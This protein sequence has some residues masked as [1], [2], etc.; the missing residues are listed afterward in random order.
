MIKETVELIGPSMMKKT[1]AIFVNPLPYLEKGKKSLLSIADIDLINALTGSFKIDVFCGDPAPSNRDELHCPIHHYLLFQKWLP[2][3]K[4]KNILYLLW[5]SGFHRYIYPLIEIFPGIVVL[6]DE[7]Q[8]E[9]MSRSFI[10]KKD[11]SEYRR[12]MVENFGNQGEIISTS[13]FLG[14]PYQFLLSQLNFEEYFSP[15]SRRVVVNYPLRRGQFSSN[16]IFSIP[17]HIPAEMNTLL[18]QE[19]VHKTKG[20]EKSIRLCFLSDLLGVL[21]AEILIGT[22]TLFAKEGYTVHLDIIAKPAHS[23]NFDELI[24]Q[25]DI[26]SFTYSIV[27]MS[28][29]REKACRLLFLADAI[30]HCNSFLPTFI[31]TLTPMFHA[32]LLSRKPVFTYL[33]MK[34][35][36]NHYPVLDS[37]ELLS[38]NA[39]SLARGILLHKSGTADTIVEGQS[40]N[41]IDF[42][43]SL[44]LKNIVERYVFIVES[45]SSSVRYETGPTNVWKQTKTDFFQGGQSLLSKSL[46]DELKDEIEKIF[47]SLSP[48][49]LKFR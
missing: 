7:N 32:A 27:P 47:N 12:K 44:L 24:Q 3:V 21:P 35:G 14:L 46:P 10:Q 38:K 30:V 13:Y 8:F 31:T 9:S 4:Y 45:T 29:D 2:R 43:D 18:L 48:T 26:P 42:D 33:G 23:F 34:Q 6:R 41:F 22:S 25:L 28:A 5:S 40:D 15:L 36:A 39:E 17:H 20:E 49:R 11:F 1:I 16:S 19:N 37:N